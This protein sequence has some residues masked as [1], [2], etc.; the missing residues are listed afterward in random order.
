[1][2]ARP[3]LCQP[4]QAIFLLYSRFFRACRFQ[5]SL[6]LIWVQFVQSLSIP[7]SHTFTYYSYLWISSW[8]IWSSTQFRR[9]DLQL[10]SKLLVSVNSWPAHFGIF[11]SL[12][13]NNYEPVRRTILLSIKLM[14]SASVFFIALAVLT[15]CSSALHHFLLSTPTVDEDRTAVRKY[16]CRS[17]LCDSMI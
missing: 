15:D 17:T 4:S 14:S 3:S 13:P 11:S 2:R 1:M 6:P 16:H 10:V 5:L 7:K 8:G 9:A 12:Y